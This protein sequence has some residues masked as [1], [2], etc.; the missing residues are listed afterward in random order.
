VIDIRGK[1][2]GQVTEEMAKLG[3]RALIEWLD[4]PTP[5][6]DQPIA[7]ATYAAK[8]DKA[9]ARIDWSKPAA[10]VERQ[11]RAFNPVP[12]AWF[13]ANGE[14]IKLLEAEIVGGSGAPGE[15]LDE[16]LTVATGS[17]AIRPLLAQRAGRGPMSAVELLRGFAILKGTIL[18]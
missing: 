17:G 9:E 16:G 15:I 7:G 18:P 1:N 10:D 5:P 8:I 13:E 12:G 14:R 3:A 4:H 11:V 2:A 6:E